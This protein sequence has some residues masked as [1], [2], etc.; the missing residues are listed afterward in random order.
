MTGWHLTKP[1]SLNGVSKKN[2]N[3]IIVHGL[4]TTYFNDKGDVSNQFETPYAVHIDAKQNNT[5]R[6]P[7]IIATPNK[8]KGAPDGNEKVILDADK[9]VY[10]NAKNESHYKG[11]VTLSQGES[12]LKS[13]SAVT[14]MDKNNKLIK[15][16]A[17]SLPNQRVHF[18]KKSDKKEPTVHA[19]ANIITYLPTLGKIILN[20][21]AFVKQGKNTYQ[22]ES[23]VYDIKKQ[24]VISKKIAKKRT[25]ITLDTKIL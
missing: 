17:K 14:W 11:N 1:P 9:L 18:W 19:Y 16:I 25:T 21:K 2:D 5:I 6:K 13:D 8:I 4:K 10:N 3:N 15:A 22:S 20:G 24:M 12:H 23:I 7:H